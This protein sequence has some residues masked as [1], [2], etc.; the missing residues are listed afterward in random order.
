MT[1]RSWGA[2]S[3]DVEVG[4]GDASYLVV[5]E[6]ANAGWEATL[7]GEQLPSVTIDGWRQGYLVPAGAGGTVELRFA[8]VAGYRAALL[9]GLVL[10]LGVV[11]GALAPDRRPLLAGLLAGRW[12]RL[13]AYVVPAVLAVAIG[14][15]VAVLL[16]VAVVLDRRRPGWRT[17]RAADRGGRPA[18]R[19]PRGRAP[20]GARS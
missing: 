19:R 9:V 13:V 10:A 6:N 4:A 3:R 15:P 16:V 11:A 1:V 2:E 7:A 14:G 18:R 17:A 20:G 12:P 8:A 5:N